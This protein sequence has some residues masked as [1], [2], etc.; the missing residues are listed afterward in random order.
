MSD[1]F[2]KQGL[3]L[4]EV[5]LIYGKT[6]ESRKIYAITVQKIDLHD[7]VLP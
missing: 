7:R 2:R 1:F 6:Q 5:F 4:S 3:I